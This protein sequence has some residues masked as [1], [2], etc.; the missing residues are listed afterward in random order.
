MAAR[1]GEVAVLG[2]MHDEKMSFTDDI[3]KLKKTPAETSNYM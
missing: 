1:Y 3:A 2:L